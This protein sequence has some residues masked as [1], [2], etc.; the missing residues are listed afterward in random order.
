MCLYI[1]HKLQVTL[2]NT[3]QCDQIGLFL[4]IPGVKFFLKK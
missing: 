4:K 2:L 3:A 1:R